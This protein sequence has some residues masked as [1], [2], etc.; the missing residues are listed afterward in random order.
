MASVNGHMICI[1]GAI[2]HFA[3]NEHRITPKSSHLCKIKSSQSLLVGRDQG[4]R[5]TKIFFCKVQVVD[6]SRFLAVEQCFAG[7]RFDKLSSAY[8][9]TRKR[10]LHGGRPTCSSSLVDNR[11]EDAGRDVLD[12]KNELN[13]E[14][15]SSS[16]TS[17]STLREERLD[18][19]EGKAAGHG[20]AKA[21]PSSRMWEWR[22]RWQV[23]FEVAGE[24]N[25]H[26]PAVLFLPGF[27]VGSFHFR[28]QLEELGRDYRVYALDF[29]G[30]GKS[31]PSHDPAP[32]VD[33]Q[34]EHA[35]LNEEEAVRK[36]TE[37]LPGVN[38]WDW[39]FGP[40]AEPW[41]E[42][43]VYSV[44]TWQAQVAAFVREV[45]KEPVFI[46]GNSLGGYVATYFA[47]QNSELV[48]GLAL[49]NATPFWAFVP[50]PAAAPRMARMVPWSGA[51][52]V[53][54]FARALARRWWD[55]LRNPATL[56][57][58]LRLVYA[59][60][61][62]IDDEMLSHIVRPTEHPAAA[63]A[64]ASILF[65]PKA[66]FSFDRNLAIV[67]DRR[68][69]VCLIYGRDDPWVVPMWGQRVKRSV[70]GATYYEITPSGHCPHHETPEVVN[71]LLKGW[72]EHQLDAATSPLPMHDISGQPSANVREW[73]RPA[74]RR[75]ATMSATSVSP[76]SSNSAP[77]SGSAPGSASKVK[78][79][80]KLKTGAPSSPV[81]FLDA[82]MHTVRAT[83]QRAV[84]RSGGSGKVE[85]GAEIVT[86]VA[87]T[88]GLSE[89]AEIA[90]DTTSNE[91]RVGSKQDDEER[92]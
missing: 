38:P 70:P 3:R 9:T 77:D 26:A 60:Q 68:L 67:K 23:H 58:L 32:V 81:E 86:G 6:G 15:A 55:D 57:G 42:D 11:L 30:Q 65:A 18:V 52:P 1:Q 8:T 14:T 61:D 62:A 31:W 49:F 69:P 12:T 47:A 79:R 66:Q 41:A 80:V 33:K 89:A 45:I 21:T 44:D 4:D 25:M 75:Q 13:K 59:S 40:Q 16:Q 46:A 54:S 87:V 17:S 56:R 88:A 91:M 10:L 83:W 90:K 82:A 48:R 7:H 37:K 78:I 92:K 64:F 36:A 50:N 20:K 35:S 84:Q 28:S 5:R 72:I 29:L 53:P 74:V 2:Q 19:K 39:G 24:E 27:G 85:K 43:L 73:T 34:A 51:L 71:E 22:H 76:S 63:A